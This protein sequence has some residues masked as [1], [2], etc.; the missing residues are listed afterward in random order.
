MP[1]HEAREPLAAH[2]Q[3]GP[4]GVAKPAELGER[5]RQGQA[6][7]QVQPALQQSGD[8]R[9][10]GSVRVWGLPQLQH[11]SHKHLRRGSKA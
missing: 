1:Q 5:R 2:A 8:L 3:Q 11:L 10:L 4:G 7:E 6:D 9:G